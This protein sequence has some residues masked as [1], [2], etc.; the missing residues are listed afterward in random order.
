MNKNDVNNLE[1]EI[2]NNLYSINR[3]TER[4]L[5]IVCII[6]ENNLHSINNSSSKK[7]KLK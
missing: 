3:P 4:L 1:Q 7:V 2:E 5:I 6:N